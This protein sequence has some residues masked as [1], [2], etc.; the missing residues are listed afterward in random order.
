MTKIRRGNFDEILLILASLVFL[1]LG[2]LRASYPHN[3]FVQ[4]YAGALAL[5]HGLDPYHGTSLVYPPSILVAVFPVALFSLRTAW[6]LWFA[7]NGALFI[8]AVHLVVGL[9]PP[10]H[11]RLAIVLGAVILAGSSQLL[12]VGQPSAP[13]IALAAIGGYCLIRDRM[14]GAGTAA[15]ALSLAI[16]PQIGGLLA[17]YWAIRGPHRRYAIAALAGFAALLVCGILVIQARAEGAQWATSMRSNL[18][19]AV[20]RGAVNSPGTADKASAELNLQTVTAVF[21]RTREIY[22]GA[23]YIVFGILLA[24]WLAAEVQLMRLIARPLQQLL[25]MGSLAVLT[26]LPVYHRSYDS[27][28]LLLALPAALIVLERRR[29]EGILLCVLTASSIVSIQH[30][31]QLGLARAGLLDRVLHNKIL[32][33][34]LLRESDLRLLMCFALLLLAAARWNAG[35]EARSRRDSMKEASVET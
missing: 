14:P 9:C 32:L 10:R 7:I 8:L 16:K 3:D 33:I 35:S 4:V 19:G 29:V 24:A 31:L 13:A 18:A 6:L 5:L 34:V 12:A 1:G 27:R 2:A 15:L 11:R 26:L 21:F 25:S 17:I 23:A 20:A 30:W 28:L 22:N